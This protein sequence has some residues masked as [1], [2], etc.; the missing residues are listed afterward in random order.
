[1]RR[2]PDVQA[3]SRLI[4][5]IILLVSDES[6]IVHGTFFSTEKKTLGNAADSVPYKS[7]LS[8]VICQRN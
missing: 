5:I 2:F 3:I 7:D 8:P 4:Y 1:M 6:F